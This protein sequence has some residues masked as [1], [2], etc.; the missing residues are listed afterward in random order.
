MR[1]G[2]RHKKQDLKCFLPE[3]EEIREACERIQK[4]WTPKERTSRGRYWEDRQQVFLHICAV[5]DLPCDFHDEDQV[6]I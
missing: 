3:P 4:T 6:T 5:V 1:D 2:R